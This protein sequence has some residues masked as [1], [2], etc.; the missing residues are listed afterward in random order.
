MQTESSLMNVTSINFPQAESLWTTADIATFTRL[1]L[2]TVQNMASRGALPTP[3]PNFG[4][5]LRWEP[6]TIRTFFGVAVAA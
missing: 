3:L 1:H 6:A 2:R 5:V 4:R